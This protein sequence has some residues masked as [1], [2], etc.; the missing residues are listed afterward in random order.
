MENSPEANLFSVT[1]ELPRILWNLKLQYRIYKS[2][3]PVPVQ[4]FMKYFVTKL[5]LYS[6]QLLAPCP[7]QTGGPLLIRCPRLLIYYIRRCSVY[8]EAAR[9]SSTWGL[10][11]ICC[12]VHITKHCPWLQS[13]MHLSCSQCTYLKINSHAF[14]I[15]F[16]GVSVSVLVFV[17]PKNMNVFYCCLLG[18]NIAFTIRA[19]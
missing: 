5:S 6:Q 9:R 11:I 12:Q 2:P 3:P 7:P 16:F 19:I 15:K 1:Q 4:V 17:I 13:L 14:S 18:G 8:L 10:A